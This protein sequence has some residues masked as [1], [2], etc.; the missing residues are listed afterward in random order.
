MR[1]LIIVIISTM[2]LVAC[3]DRGPAEKAGEEIDEAMERA[4]N[5]MRD[6]G[7]QIDDAVDNA[8]EN[9]REAMDE[10][11]D[12]VGDAARDA[13]DAMRDAARK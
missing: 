12:A 6:A 10:A 5:E 3:E 7:I 9:S 13:E 8:M 4:G 1:K 2:A 11:A